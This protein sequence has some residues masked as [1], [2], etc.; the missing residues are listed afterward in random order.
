MVGKVLRIHFVTVLAV[1]VS[2][3]RST[4]EPEGIAF[5]KAL[6]AS[7]ISLDRLD[8]ILDRSF[9]L[10]NGDLNGLLY[11]EAGS[12]I[13]RISKNDVWDARLDTANDPPLPTLKRL[14]ELAYGKWSDRKWILPKGYELKGK[15]AITSILILRPGHVR[16]SG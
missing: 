1:A 8:D 5:P 15:T 10:G 16:L 12:L 14:N 13:L 2:A 7:V 6:D 4:A 3:V 9:I 11:E